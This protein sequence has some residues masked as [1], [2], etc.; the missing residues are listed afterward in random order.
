MAEW[1]YRKGMKGT[2]AFDVAVTRKGFD[3]DYLAIECNPRF[4]G[5]SYPTAIAPKLGLESWLARVFPTHYRSLSFLQ[6]A[7]IEY[8]PHRGE[9]VVLVNWGPIFTGKLLCL[10]AGPK[11]VQ[12]QLILELERR[13]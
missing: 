4:N 5:A 8:N 6:L 7:G 11:T 3:T 2:F 12:E 13:L 10:I 9:G 1:L